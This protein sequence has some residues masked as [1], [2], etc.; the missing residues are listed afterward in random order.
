MKPVLMI[1]TSHDQLGNTGKPTGLW[2]EELT[3]PRYA[4]VD[5]GFDVVLATPKGGLPPFAAGSVK[6]AP[7]KNEGTV[8]R[9]L[10]FGLLTNQNGRKQLLNQ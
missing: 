1:I 8:K 3:T 5:A 10:A 7:Q 4:M 2:A 6:V 9:F